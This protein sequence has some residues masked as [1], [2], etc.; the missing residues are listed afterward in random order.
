M[1]G[2]LKINIENVDP[3]TRNQMAKI[4]CGDG[5]LDVESERTEV[6]PPVIAWTFQ[7]LSLASNSVGG[8]VMFAGRVGVLIRAVL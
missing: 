3:I 8:A 1:A 2:Q 5:R 4:L 7:V 6:S